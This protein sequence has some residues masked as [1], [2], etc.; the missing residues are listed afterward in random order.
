MLEI[1]SRISKHKV[2]VIKLFVDKILGS[3]CM[4]SAVIGFRQTEK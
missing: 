3:L 2:F 4:M 1:H